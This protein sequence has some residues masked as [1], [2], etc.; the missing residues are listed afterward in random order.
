MND[1]ELQELK[2]QLMRLDDLMKLLIAKECN[3]MA[4]LL[5]GCDCCENKGDVDDLIE[6]Y[7]AGDA[8]LRTEKRKQKH[9]KEYKRKKE[10]ALKNKES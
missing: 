8:K 9:E 3:C 4:C 5:K 10:E 2:D 1:F 7:Q 6:K